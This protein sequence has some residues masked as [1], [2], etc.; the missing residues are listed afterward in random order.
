MSVADRD[1]LRRRAILVA[2]EVQTEINSQAEFDDSVENDTEQSCNVEI[3]AR[4]RRHTATN[5][6]SSSNA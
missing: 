1:I 5:L 6:D 4:G 2:F 3:L